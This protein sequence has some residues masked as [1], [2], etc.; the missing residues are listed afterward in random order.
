MNCFEG[1]ARDRITAVAVCTAVCLWSIAARADV[2][3]GYLRLP[4]PIALAMPVSGIVAEVHVAPGRRVA[5][6]EP[7]VSVSPAAFALAVDQAQAEI[8]RL[9]PQL[10]AAEREL[11]QAEEL[12]AR[13][14]LSEFDRIAAQ[15]AHAKAEAAFRRATAVLARAKLDLNNTTLRAAAPLLIVDVLTAPGVAVLTGR[16][17]SNVLEAI[18]LSGAWTEFRVPQSQVVQFQPGSRLTLSRGGDADATVKGRVVEWRTDAGTDFASASSVILRVYLS[19]AAL[20]RFD[21]GEEVRLHYER[22]DADAATPAS[23]TE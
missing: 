11:T 4:Q 9:Q 5:S 18:S 1:S 23:A 10:D 14:V 19:G 21:A 6:G 17:S 16:E 7:L 3:V 2:S 20:G 15:E 12:Y 8:D 22:T 13:T